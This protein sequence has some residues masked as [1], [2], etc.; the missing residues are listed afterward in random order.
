MRTI[1]AAL[2][3]V[4]WDG[5]YR[6]TVAAA[7]T[8]RIVIAI[9]KT[10]APFVQPEVVARDEKLRDRWRTI[11]MGTSAATVLIGGATLFL[12]KRH[13]PNFNIHPTSQRT[14]ASATYTTTW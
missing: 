8:H 10:Q 2:V 4:A 3:V 9:G 14:G 6:V 11:A 5:R 1:V 13:E 12:W 7:G